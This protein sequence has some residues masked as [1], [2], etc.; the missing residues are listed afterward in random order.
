MGK[1]L[2]TPW[3]GSFFCASLLLNS[4]APQGFE[5][6]FSFVAPY[7]NCFNATSTVTSRR[8]RRQRRARPMRRRAPRSARRPSDRSARRPAAPPTP[9]CRRGPS[10]PRRASA[11]RSPPNSCDVRAFSCG[12]E[13]SSFLRASSTSST[14]AP[15]PESAPASIA[16]RAPPPTW[17]SAPTPS[18]SLSSLSPWL[19]AWTPPPAAR[20]S[21]SAGDPKACE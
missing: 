16:W 20:S 5:L 17:P 7:R 18:T 13:R 9:I 3:E 19:A 6:N 12:G 1:S 4:K 14:P 8:P 21:S 15:W 11:S 2:M 10:R